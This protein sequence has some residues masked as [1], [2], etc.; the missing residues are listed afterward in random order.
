M[1]LRLTR[2]ALRDLDLSIEKY[3]RKSATEY[4]DD[5]DMV[6]SFVE[7][8]SQSPVGQETT[9]LPVTR[10]TV[11]NIHYGRCR[12]LTWHDVNADV[13]WLLGVGWHETGSLDDA[14]VQIKNRDHHERLMPTVE[15]Y[16]DLELTQAET[17]DFI[18]QVSIQA[19]SL[20]ETARLY[21]GVEIPGVIAERIKVSVLV[22]V[23]PG[24]QG[25]ESLED[26]YISFEMPPIE[27]PCVLPTQP[28]WI[29]IVLAAMLPEA[30]SN[31]LL[32][33]A[34]FPRN[35]GSRS[36]EIVVRYS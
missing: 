26:I 8:R 1:Q 24:D 28:E 36:N 14:Y 15:D 2:Q 31:R 21:P 34:N 3:S 5:N 30:D 13:V 4:V 7:M 22:Y 17:L 10:A 33:G 32:F 19:P 35:G 23:I 29:Q 20:L 18:T 27:G 16:R 9:R 25:F 11:W 6:A 12:G